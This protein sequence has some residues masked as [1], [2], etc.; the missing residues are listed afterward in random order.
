MDYADDT[1]LARLKAKYR[2][3]RISREEVIDY[4]Y[5]RRF[6]RRHDL[7]K[8]RK[9]IYSAYRKLF[10]LAKPI[11]WERILLGLPRLLFYSLLEPNLLRHRLEIG[12][13]IAI[14]I[15]LI[16][17]QQRRWKYSN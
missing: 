15:G 3:G 8:S 13:D 10:S 11:Q 4:V 1:T 14:E 7:L 9:Q 17:P 12:E 5:S 2:E 6:P 16:E